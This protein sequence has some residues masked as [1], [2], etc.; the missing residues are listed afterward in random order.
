MRNLKLFFVAAILVSIFSCTTEKE[1]I[2]LEEIVEVE[3]L[4]ADFQIST[5]QAYDPNLFLDLNNV[6]E[7][8]PF[9]MI[10]TNRND[11]DNTATY[12]QVWERRNE[13]N[14]ACQDGTY[15]SDYCA[16]LNA[17]YTMAIRIY[18]FDCDREGFCEN[19]IG[20]MGF[21]YA[22]VRY[23]RDDLGLHEV[24]VNSIQA[25]V[26]RLELLFAQC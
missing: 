4:N 18:Q 10:V 26:D 22:Q 11:C 16:Y 12:Q 5:P 3:E 23:L 24:Y 15:T 17:Y 19:T 9:Q 25:L 20:F 7:E 14:E 1:D 2:I 13:A 8:N 6:H 21:M